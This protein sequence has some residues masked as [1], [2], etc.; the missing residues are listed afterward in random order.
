MTPLLL[1]PP[2][3]ALLLLGAW[4]HRAIVRRRVRRWVS[5]RPGDRTLDGCLMLHVAGDDRWA[6]VER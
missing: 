3:L 6:E 5:E 2:A 4:A 1:L